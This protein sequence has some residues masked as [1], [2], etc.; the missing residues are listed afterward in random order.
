M[1]RTDPVPAAVRTAASDAELA[2]AVGAA[3]SRPRVGPASSFVLHAPLELA[4]R[5]ALLPLV[6][7]GHRAAAREHIHSIATEYD[8]AGAAVDAPLPVEH[9]SIAAATSALAEA[10]DAGDLDAVDTTA[11]WLGDHATGAALRAHLTD[12]VLPR[13]AAAAHAPI[14]LYQLPRVASRGELPST[15]LRPLAR[16]LARHPDWRLTWFDALGPG[17]RA[18]AE[19]LWEAVAATPRLGSPGSD[20]I[21]PLMSQAEE[22]GVASELLA[23]PVAGVDL[24]G[25]ARVLLRA[26]ALTMLQEPPDYAPYGWSHCLTMPQAVL[27]TA[28]AARDPRRAL[29]VAATFVVGFRAALAVNPLTPEY[30]P[31]NPG[32]GLDT[33]L[34]TGPAVAAGAAWHTPVRDRSRLVTAL[35]TRASTHPD[36]HLVKYTLACLDAAA[37][38]PPFAPTYLA[39]AASLAGYWATG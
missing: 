12:V 10:I 21:F 36:A 9:E 7:P 3:V 6:A 5:V 19:A 23:A 30:A 34:D 32:I 17:G 35:A 20:F 2:A 16:E 1:T 25:G 31:A 37:W 29:A 4:A 28:A 15:L 22:S 39:A 24:D 38:D 33:A 26:A 18:P 11:A 8:A 14:L 27:G 13:L